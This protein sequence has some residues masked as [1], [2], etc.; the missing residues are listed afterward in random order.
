MA[1]YLTT[2]ATVLSS[3]VGVGHKSDSVLK[4]MYY[5]EVSYEYT[6]NGVTYQGNCFWPEKL[7]L[8]QADKIQS[9]IAQY[10]VGAQVMVYYNPQNPTD[11]YLQPL[12][13]SAP[14][15][16]M[17]WAMIFGLF[18]MVVVIAAVIFLI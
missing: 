18:F 16:M 3:Q 8:N 1:E 14:N 13:G 17:L 10:P 11:A 7:Q 6:V 4:E 12:T 5:P 2:Q 15:Q 9:A